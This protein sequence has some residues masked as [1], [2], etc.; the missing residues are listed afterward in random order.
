MKDAA[1]DALPEC[2]TFSADA[3]VFKVKDVFC[4]DVVD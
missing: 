4:F 1:A 3:A 2:T